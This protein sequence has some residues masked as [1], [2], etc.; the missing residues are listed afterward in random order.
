MPFSRAEFHRGWTYR[1]DL[2]SSEEKDEKGLTFNTLLYF[3]GQEKNQPY[4]DSLRW[5]L[6][7]MVSF[8][9]LLEWDKEEAW[10]P[11]DPAKDRSDISR[12]AFCPPSTSWQGASGTPS[13]AAPLPGPSSTP[14]LHQLLRQGPLFYYQQTNN[15]G[16]R[17]SE[18]WVRC[19]F[20]Q[21]FHP[22][23]AQHHLVPM[24][25]WSWVLGA[26]GAE[27][28]GPG[29]PVGRNVIFSS[30]ECEA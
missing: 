6:N 25:G 30:Q 22:S 8:L 21:K 20:P 2:C 15:L 4:P 3:L 23:S 14:F 24:G 26:R 1:G 29:Y 27:K 13:T 19:Q 10:V 5:V 16:A 18:S 12:W 28:G 9:V 11:R 17:F 7:R